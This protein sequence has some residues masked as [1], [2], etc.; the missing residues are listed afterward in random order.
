[1]KCFQFCHGW[2][3]LLL[4]YY[5]LSEGYLSQSGD[6]F[7]RPN[8]SIFVNERNV[9]DRRIHIRFCVTLG[10]ILPDLLIK[11]S[12]LSLFY[13]IFSLE[14]HFKQTQT[15]PYTSL[16]LYYLYQFPLFLF[17]IGRIQ[18]YSLTLRCSKIM[19]PMFT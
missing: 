18:T 7:L 13:S 1:M 14:S 15:C 10:L 12:F 6:S 4:R 3:S 5:Y 17:T 8:F 19:E 9:V 16:W 2:Q 11:N